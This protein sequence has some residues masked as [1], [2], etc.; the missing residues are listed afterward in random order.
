MSLPKKGKS[1]ESKTM[2]KPDTWYGITLNPA[3]QFRNAKPWDR[4]FIWSYANFFHN[5]LSVMPFF[6]DIELYPEYSPGQ[7]IKGKLQ[8]IIPRLHFH[9]RVKVDVKRFYMSGAEKLLLFC[10]FDISNKVDMEYCKKNQAVMQNIFLSDYPLI[11]YKL[12]LKAINSGKL[13]KFMQVWYESCAEQTG[14]KR[15]FT[16]GLEDSDSEDEQEALDNGLA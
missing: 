7:H 14:G 9:G 12:G 13:R 5:L 10:T 16:L 3:D 11:P 1:T 15:A 4:Q 6:T 8:S 2:L